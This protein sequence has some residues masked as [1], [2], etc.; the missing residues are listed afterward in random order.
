HRLAKRGLLT[1]I[2][3]RV[4]PVAPFTVV[5]LV[6]GASHI[7]FRDFV[8]GTVIGELPGL[9]AMS[10]FFDNVMEAIRHPGPISFLV[11]AAVAG[12]IAV[13]ALGLRRWLSK[14][15]NLHPTAAAR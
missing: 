13:G 9:A 4:L 8:L 15:T 12:A 2:A 10:A 6:A 7:G 14:R 5:N 3:V 11:L 1:V